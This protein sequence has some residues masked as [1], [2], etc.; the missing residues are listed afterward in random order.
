MLMKPILRCLVF[1]LALF[2]V[3]LPGQA[4]MVGT[5]QMQSGQVMPSAGDLAA[6]R[7]WIVE[8]LVVGGVAEDDAAARVLAMTDT[9]VRSLHQRIQEHPAAGADGLVIL[10]LVLVITELMGYTDIVPGWPA[11]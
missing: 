8:Q 11:E 6:Q 3:S 7:D 10:I 9:Q 4:A 5:A 1:S 2:T